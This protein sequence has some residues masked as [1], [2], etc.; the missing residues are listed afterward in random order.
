MRE[1][2]TF[3]F[4]KNNPSALLLLI[5]TIIIILYPVLRGN[6]LGGLILAFVTV[7]MVGSILFVVK[8]TPALFWVSV[9]FGVP[10]VVFSVLDVFFPAIFWI[11]V[12][13][14][15][16]HVCFYF[17]ASYALIRYIFADNEVTSDEWYATAAAFTVI[18]WAFAYIFL[19]TDVLV[20]GSFTLF[21]LRD[22][23]FFE[24]L[25]LSFSV[26]TGVGLSDIIPSSDQG[27][28]V[29]MVA[30]VVGVF[31]MALIVSRL[32]AM[33]VARKEGHVVKK[34]TPKRSR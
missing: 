34:G 13:S 22:N 33:G 19:L 15:I 27:R 11:M 30:D 7:G 6:L 29:L 23:S 3:V 12:I 16:A 20:P 10:S 14:C 4:F 28:S 2:K 1:L 24:S 25:F 18:L 17:Y 31:Y 21:D 9:L 8:H 32:V 5:Q 26:L